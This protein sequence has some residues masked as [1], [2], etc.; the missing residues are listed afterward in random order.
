MAIDL[1]KCV[2]IWYAELSFGSNFM[3][4][5]ERG[6]GG[7]VLKLR[8]RLRRDNKTHDSADERLWFGRR[9]TITREALAIK[10]ARKIVNETVLEI[11]LGPYPVS[12]F[13]AGPDGAAG[14]LK[15][16]EAQPWAHQQTR[17]VH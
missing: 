11:P 15:Q 6:D 16:L 7:F 13:I 10:L 2:A 1:Q 12:E 8:V 5:L 9:M 4:G 17:S 14:L 3:A